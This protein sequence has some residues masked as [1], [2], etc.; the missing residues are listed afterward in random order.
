MYP[1]KLFQLLNP[2]LRQLFVLL[3]CYFRIKQLE[4]KKPT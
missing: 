3:V 4:N 2:K 1:V